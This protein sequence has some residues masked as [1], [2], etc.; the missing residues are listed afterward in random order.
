MGLC[1]FVVAEDVFPT[2]TPLEDMHPSTYADPHNDTQTIILLQLVTLVHLVLFLWEAPSFSL[3]G[4]VQMNKSMVW[5]TCCRCC[6][7]HELVDPDE[8]VFHEGTLLQSFALRF[9]EGQAFFCFQTFSQLMLLRD[10]CNCFV[11]SCSWNVT[12]STI[13]AW[14]GHLAAVSPPAQTFPLRSYLLMRWA[15][16]RRWI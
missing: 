15:G 1:N 3:A 9:S 12:C 8:S 6:L 14:F 2:V 10:C 13:L 16:F 11:F 5:K 7:L 4:N